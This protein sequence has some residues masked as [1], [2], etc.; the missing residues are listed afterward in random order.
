MT[1]KEMKDWMAKTKIE[2]ERAIDEDMPKRIGNRVVRMTKQN[3]QEEGFFGK[4]W[5]EMKKRHLLRRR[6][7]SKFL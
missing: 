1:L 2:I 6:N 3:F 7:R 5:K 4:R